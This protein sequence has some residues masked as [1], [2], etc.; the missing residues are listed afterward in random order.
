MQH[1]FTIDNGVRLRLHEE[2]GMTAAAIFSADERH[3]YVLWREWNAA[4]PLITWFMLNPSTATH[5]VLDP[6]IRGC[7]QRAM[8]W[9]YGRLVVVNLFALR[10]TDPAGLALVSDPVGNRNDAYID[11]ALAVS[12]RVV[13][14]W[15][16]ASAVGRRGN[17]VLARMRQQGVVPHA[18]ATNRNGSPKHPLYVAHSLR[19]TPLAHEP[20]AA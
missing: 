7:L 1:F 20:V 11:Q 17:D 6:T 14:G 5:E 16:N 10:S 18:L 9:G 19:P 8:Q 4:L 3:R 2:I 15:G 13:C 12:D